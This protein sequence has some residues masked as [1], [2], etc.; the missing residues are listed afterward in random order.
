MSLIGEVYI[1]VNFKKTHIRAYQRTHTY[2]ALAATVL[3]TTHE[4]TDEP[5]S[6]PSEVNAGIAPILQMRKLRCRETKSVAQSRA[7]I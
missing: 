7:G 2:E 1:H 5:P 3:S 4:L 6:N